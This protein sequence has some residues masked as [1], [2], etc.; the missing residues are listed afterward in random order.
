[1]GY[2]KWAR[3]SVGMCICWG[4]VLDEFNLD[5]HEL[6]RYWSLVQ[7]KSDTCCLSLFCGGS[8]LIGDCARGTEQILPGEDTTEGFVSHV[9]GHWQTIFK[10]SWIVCGVH[11]LKDQEGLLVSND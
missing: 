3:I 7:S 1:M 6:N 9:Q 11:R 5:G 2:Q 10:L 4:W 8:E